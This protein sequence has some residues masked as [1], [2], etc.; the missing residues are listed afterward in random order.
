MYFKIYQEFT[1]HIA[2]LEFLLQ[3]LNVLNK[4]RIVSKH[5]FLLNLLL[6]KVENLAMLSN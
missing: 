4:W 6:V 2:I 5:A 1:I 3:Y